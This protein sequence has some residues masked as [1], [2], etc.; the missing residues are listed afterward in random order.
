[1]FGEK[2]IR[3]WEVESREKAAEEEVERLGLP[4][5]CVQGCK[6]TRFGR[7]LIRTNLSFLP[8]FL[9]G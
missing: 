4:T 9:S 5:L 1:M 3:L 6:V 8:F 7:V 2:E